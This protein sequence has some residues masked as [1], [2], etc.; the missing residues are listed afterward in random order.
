MDKKI[1]I[2]MIVLFSFVVMSG[3]VIGSYGDPT[4]YYKLTQ[5]IYM[6]ATNDEF[7]P[8]DPYCTD[9]FLA[10]AEGC[11]LGESIEENCH[12][13]SYGGPWGAYPNMCA[14]NL[15]VLSGPY[16]DSGCTILSPTC[17]TS[18]TKVIVFKDVDELSEDDEIVEFEKDG[19]K[20]NL[21][22]DDETGE[23]KE[24]PVSWFKRIF[25]K[26]KGFFG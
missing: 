9:N 4:K 24:V 12:I 22:Y 17:F 5:D 13:I 19:R 18:G 2:G 14:F 6:C 3:S 21:M 23:M 8:E 26:I 10:N 1:I 20:Y 7:P 16:E 15:I 25:D 11:S